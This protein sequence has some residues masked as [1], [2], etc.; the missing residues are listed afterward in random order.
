MA[1]IIKKQIIELKVSPHLN[2][3]E[4]QQSM[5]EHYWQSLLPYLERLFEEYNDANQVLAID[6]LELDLGAI[7][8]DD[9]QKGKVGYPD[10]RA[11]IQKFFHTPSA[12]IQT[13]SP[14]LNACQQWLYYMRSGHLPWSSNKINQQWYQLVLES[15]ATDIVSVDRLRRIILQDHQVVRRL[16]FQH[17]PTF[18]KNLVEVI[19]AHKQ[20]QLLTTLD[21]LY[22]WEHYGR[23]LRGLKPLSKKSFLQNSW[24]Q[25][26]TKVAQHPTCGADHQTLLAP[27]VTSMAL[28]PKGQKKLPAQLQ[29]NLRITSNWLSS[30]QSKTEVKEPSHKEPAIHQKDQIYSNED[31]LKSDA[32][33]PEDKSKGIFTDHAGLVL[34][35]PFLN[36][37]FAKIK[38]VKDGDFINERAR[39]QAILLLHYMATGKQQA[40]ECQLVI[41]KLL[42]GVPL[43]QPVPGKLSLS[44]KCLQEVEL[45][46]EVIIGRWEALKNTTAAGLQEEFLQ[47]PGKLTPG[48]EFNKLQVEAKTLDI[49]LDRL[50]WNIS[51][52][53]LPWMDKMLHVEWR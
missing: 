30:P 31:L 12:Q 22:L 1:H 28:Q 50:P 9:L 26:L 35:H 33:A 41:P 40:Q 37:L 48:K 23:K 7:N 16:Y 13:K 6:Y 52:I 47:R 36:S 38:R 51:L 42:C 49:L 15:L 18:L 19:S 17:T 46:L 11:Q 34:V 20:D 14:A 43:S 44:K 45:L 5:S 32:S 25:I 10:L 53:K 4:V 27:L 2:A 24:E 39:H 29:G 8:F 3:F 21:E